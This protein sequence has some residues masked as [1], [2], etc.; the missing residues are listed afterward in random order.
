MMIWS[1]NP[2]KQDIA[3]SNGHSEYN[4]PLRSYL[5][6]KD[7][8]LRNSLLHPGTYNTRDNFLLNSLMVINKSE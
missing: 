2:D 5:D 3:Y 6:L 7:S 1:L 4:H 8:I